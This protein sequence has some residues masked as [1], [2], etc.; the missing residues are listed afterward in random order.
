MENKTVVFDAQREIAGLKRR[1]EYLEKLVPNYNKAVAYDT[2]TYQSP[3]SDDY[4]G[5]N[6]FFNDPN[7]PFP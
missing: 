5:P 7:R 4:K 1:V 6:G 2:H 3:W